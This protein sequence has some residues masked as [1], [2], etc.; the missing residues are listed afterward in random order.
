MG[1][2]STFRPAGCSTIFTSWTSASRT[3]KRVN[4][5]IRGYGKLGVVGPF[6]ALFGKD[7]NYVAEVASVFAEMFYRFGYLRVDRFLDRDAWDRLSAGLRERF[8]GRDVR[9]SEVVADFGAPSIVA[10]N[11]VFCYARPT[12][13]VGCSWI[14]SPS[15]SLG[16]FPAREA[17]RGCMM[18]PLSCAPAPACR[19]L[20]VVVSTAVAHQT[21]QLDACLASAGRP[22]RTSNSR[23]GRCRSP[24]RRRNRHSRCRRRCA[25]R[26][27]HPH[28]SGAVPGI[29]GLGQAESTPSP[30]W[31]T[32]DD[33][34]GND[35]P[36]CYYDWRISV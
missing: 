13:P 35:G 7:G 31:H 24:A 19:G 17:M 6:I 4:D 25:C 2:R 12:G 28:W 9:R 1:G 22:W 29:I 27:R 10:G 20:R 26:K 18:R 3:W 30:P 14:A 16:T 23:S 32:I 21:R 15:T 34:C 33:R 8:A 5:V 36:S 11:R